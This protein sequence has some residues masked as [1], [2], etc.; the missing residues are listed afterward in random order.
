MDSTVQAFAQGY[1]GKAILRDCLVQTNMPDPRNASRGIGG[2]VSFHRDTLWDGGPIR[3]AYLHLFLLLTDFTRENGATIVVP[4]THRLREPGYYFKHSDPR[5]Q[6]DGIDYRVYERRYF[7]SS[8]QLE[9]PKGS[10]LILDPMT[11]HTQGINITEHP[12]SL[13]NMTFRA[14]DVAG[15]PRLLNA[16]AIAERYARVPV[17]ADLLEILEADPTL[18][19]HFGPLGNAAAIER[20]KQRATWVVFNRRR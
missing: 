20:R 5:T 3:P 17:R 12:R 10:L 1:L 8:V 11:I 14:S 6:Q 18:P 4:G 16:R 13:L 19:A 2:D 7:A 9:A 15:M